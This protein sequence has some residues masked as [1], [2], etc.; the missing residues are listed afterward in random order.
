MWQKISSSF[1]GQPKYPS[2]GV[3]I[4][5]YDYVKDGNLLKSDSG[6]PL[7]QVT[8]QLGEDGNVATIN[9]DFD[10]NTLQVGKLYKINIAGEDRGFI[11]RDDGN[12][13]QFKS[14]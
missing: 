4:V 6:G 3:P 8:Y 1:V 13:E 9:I 2:D 7:F 11:L 10:H 14:E 12:L 5:K